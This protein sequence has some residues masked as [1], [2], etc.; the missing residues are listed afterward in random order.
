MSDS[1]TELGQIR[2][3]IDAL[4]TEIVALLARREA[5]VRQA[6]PLKA[7]VQ[8]VRAPDRVTQVIARVRALAETAGGEPDVVERIYRELIQAFIDLETA[9]HHR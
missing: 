7:D 8:A 6:A 9:E 5:L 3:S 1:A 2:A 4:D